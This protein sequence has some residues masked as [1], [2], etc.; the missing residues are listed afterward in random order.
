MIVWCTPARSWSD[1]PP[2]P[3]AFTRQRPHEL[4]ATRVDGSR[5]TLFE[6]QLAGDTLRGPTHPTSRLSGVVHGVTNAS[7][8]GCRKPF[9][10]G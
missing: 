2:T 1:A 6:P 9:A 4:R 3:E 10:D 7:L 5:V 8:G